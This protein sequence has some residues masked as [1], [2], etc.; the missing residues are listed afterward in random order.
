MTSANAA[1]AHRHGHVQRAEA[2]L[3]PLV[4][5]G[6]IHQTAIQYRANFIDGIG[7]LQP[8]VFDVN[9]RLRDAEGS[10]R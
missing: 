5:P 8:A 1:G 4:W 2:A 7:K 9:A 3:K 6:F 10:G